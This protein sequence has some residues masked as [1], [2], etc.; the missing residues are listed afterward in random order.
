MAIVELAGLTAEWAIP[1]GC[2]GT[3]TATVRAYEPQSC[4]LACACFERM[5]V[6]AM[7]AGCMAQ[8]THVGCH[9]AWVT[10]SRRSAN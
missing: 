9:V 3:V 1:I 6:A 8:C 4:R 10:R 5:D 7:S 2:S